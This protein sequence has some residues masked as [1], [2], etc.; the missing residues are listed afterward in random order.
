MGVEATPI[1]MSVL[2]KKLNTLIDERQMKK[3]TAVKISNW[4]LRNGYLQESSSESGKKVR[5]PSEQGRQL[6]ISS[7][8]LYSYKMK[9]D[10][11]AQRFV[12]DHIEEITCPREHTW[13]WGRQGRRGWGGDE[14]MARGVI[15]PN[16]GSA[17]SLAEEAL[18]G[19]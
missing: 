14:G 3:L 9:Y 7:E 13:G 8:V 18:G 15:E 16:E 4:L 11:T 5:L 19:H 12:L 6:G 2:C 1:E 17:A 10:E